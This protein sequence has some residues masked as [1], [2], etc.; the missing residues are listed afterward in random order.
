MYFELNENDTLPYT[1]KID[2]GCGTEYARRTFFLKLIT[3][4]VFTVVAIQSSQYLTLDFS[5]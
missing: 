4:D 1:V 3:K 5:K 2:A